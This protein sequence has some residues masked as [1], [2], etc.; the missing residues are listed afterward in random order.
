MSMLNALER[1]DV[2]IVLVDTFAMASYKSVLESKS[3]KVKALINAN[4]GYGFVLAGL[5]QTLKP[6][7]A[8]MIESRQKVISDFISSMKDKVPV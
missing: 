5:S 7:I 8:S 6:T 4:T 1:N 3:Q 2:G